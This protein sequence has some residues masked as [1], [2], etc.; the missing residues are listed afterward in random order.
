MNLDD[1]RQRGKGGKAARRPCAT[2]SR[3][4]T[5]TLGMCWHSP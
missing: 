2:V 1:E 4:V 5:A 3:C